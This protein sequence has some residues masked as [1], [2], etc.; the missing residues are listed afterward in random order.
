MR[1][2]WLLRI[3]IAN[4][5]FC[6]SDLGGKMIGILVVTHGN[7]AREFVAVLEQ[8]MGPQPNVKAFGLQS[9]ADLSQAK[10]DLR[11]MIA[12]VDDGDGV[13]LLTDMFGGTPTNLA[14]SLAHEKNIEVLAGV[15]L[16]M[17]VELVNLRKDQTLSTAIQTARV[18][19]QNYMNIA[20]F[21]MA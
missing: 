12:L 5:L 1:H 10:E 9:N 6:R 8:I 4:W 2:I 15:N 14:I 20:S 19:G 13:A 7:L 3:V 11:K 21:F 17:L 16:P 18:A